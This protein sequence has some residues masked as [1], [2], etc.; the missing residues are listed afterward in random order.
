MTKRPIFLLVPLFLF[1]VGTADATN[2]HLKDGSIV[3][4]SITGLALNAE[5]FANVP[6]VES[7][8]GLLGSTYRMRSFADIDATLL[9]LPSLE[10]SDRVRVQFDAV[11]NF[12]LYADLDFQITVYDRYD[13]QPPAGNDKNDTGLTLGLSWSY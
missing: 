10:D 11:M 8:E 3:V 6:S 12:D 13:S 2:V 1:S 7:L 9:V 4:G 5:R